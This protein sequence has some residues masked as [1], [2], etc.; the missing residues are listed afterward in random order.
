MR[1]IFLEADVDKSGFLSIEELFMALKKFGADVLQ[2]D[3]VQLMSEIDVDRNG[4]LDI[5]EFVSLIKFGDQLN[6]KNQN[7]RNILS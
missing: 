1:R 3:I 6:L 2:E 5:D 7:S 4:E